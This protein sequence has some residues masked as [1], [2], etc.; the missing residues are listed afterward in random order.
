[1]E[2][3]EPVTEV[4]GLMDND[5]AELIINSPSEIIPITPF[6]EIVSRG[7]NNPDGKFILPE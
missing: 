2:S 1:M 6:T 3:E 4:T 7:G 5:Y